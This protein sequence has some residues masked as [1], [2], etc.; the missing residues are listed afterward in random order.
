MAAI[1]FFTFAPSDSPGSSPFVTF[2]PVFHYGV[3]ALGR[4]WCYQGLRENV[5][6]LKNLNKNEMRN[7][8][9]S[10]AKIQ[11]QVMNIC[12]LF[13]RLVPRAGVEP[14]RPYGQRIL[15]P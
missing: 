13:M 2:P 6:S 10:V 3:S 4:R 7:G 5:V 9:N 11:T 1:L 12:K 14:A 8:L 15:S